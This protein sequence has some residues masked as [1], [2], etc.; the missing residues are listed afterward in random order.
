MEA[1]QSEEPYVQGA[2]AHLE[3]APESEV[4]KVFEERRKIIKTANYKMQVKGVEESLV[5]IE[6]TI[7]SFSGFI[8]NM[9]MTT[10][11]YQINNRIEIKVPNTNF[12]ALLK[13][14]R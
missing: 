13:V 4:E 8:A 1:N 5:R 10:S 7:Q 2:V 12:E 14:L 6:E 9:D 3:E 11:S